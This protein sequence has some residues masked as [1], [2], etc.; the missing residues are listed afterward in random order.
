MTDWAV[1]VG[2]KAEYE[3]AEGVR[4][5]QDIVDAGVS[6]AVGV[7]VSSM[8]WLSESS[9]R[10][11]VELLADRLL[12]DPVLQ[13]CR[14][15]DYMVRSGSASPGW[16]VEV[17][18]KPGV[19]DAVGDSVVKGARDLGVTTLADAATGRRV[20]LTGDLD[21]SSALRIAERLLMN[22]VIQTCDVR[23]MATDPV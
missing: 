9:S 10:A 12:T 16:V 6:A 17:R 22:D 3:D 8:Y 14:V 4:L 7:R 2:T 18:L 15:N 11:D 5:E 1:E 21:E 19:T 13:E 23:R 20:Y